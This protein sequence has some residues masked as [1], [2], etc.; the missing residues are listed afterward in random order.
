MVMA[1]M[2]ATLGP[3]VEHSACGPCA[4]AGVHLCFSASV[5]ESGFLSLKSPSACCL[6]LSVLRLWAFAFLLPQ[7]LGN[8]KREGGYA[9]VGLPNIDTFRKTG[10]K[11][12]LSW[13]EHLGF[14]SRSLRQTC[15]WLERGSGQDDVET[16]T[17]MLLQGSHRAGGR[18]I[19]QFFTLREG[20]LRSHNLW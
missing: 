12:V 6:G 18:R 7:C 9:V 2:R 11:R 13:P 5:S 1:R 4:L 3:T 20:L 19:C 10:P 14:S 15:Q 8:R 17:P 16:A